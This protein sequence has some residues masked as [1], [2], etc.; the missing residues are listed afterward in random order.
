MA[1]MILEEDKEI[2]KK[3]NSLSNSNADTVIYNKLQDDRKLVYKRAIP[4]LENVINSGKADA[5]IAKTLS[6]LYSAIDEN[7]KAKVLK[8]KFGL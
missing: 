4:Y 7:E 5:D 3:M 8:A 2:L 6:S 1:A